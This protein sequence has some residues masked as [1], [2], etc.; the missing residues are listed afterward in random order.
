ME[1]AEAVQSGDKK[2]ELALEEAR[3]VMA[4]FTTNEIGQLADRLRPTTTLAD[5]SY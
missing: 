5:A 4:A 1:L 2:L 3:Q